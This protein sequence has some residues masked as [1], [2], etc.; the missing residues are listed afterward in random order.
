MYFIIVGSVITLMMVTGIAGFINYGTKSA[1][2]NSM[3]IASAILLVVSIILHR[4]VRW[5]FFGATK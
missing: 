2:F 3:P 1:E 4:A 5:A